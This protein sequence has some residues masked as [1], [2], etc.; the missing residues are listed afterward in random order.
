MSN[1]RKIKLFEAF[2]W[3]GSQHQALKN[4][5]IETE[6]VW[7][8]DWFISA[9]VSYWVTHLWIKPEKIDR[10]ETIE[11]LSQFSLSSD[12]KKPIKSLKSISEEHLSILEQ[13][14]KKYWELD[15]TK[16]KWEN[17]WE[18]DLFT[19]S[20]P[21]F[22]WDTKVYT[23]NWYKNIKDVEVWDM[24]LTHTWEYKKVLSVF[25]NWE[26]EVYKVNWKNTYDLYVTPNH[27]FFIREHISE[28]DENWI[29]FPIKDEIWFK[30][31]WSLPWWYENLRHY[32]WFPINK[33]E[34]EFFLENWRLYRNWLYKNREF[35]KFVWLFFSRWFVL[36]WKA[37]WVGFFIENIDLEMKEWLC[38][39]LQEH[40]FFYKIKTIENWEI[41]KWYNFFVEEK[42][43]WRFFKEFV[44]NENEKQ[45]KFIDNRILNLK[46]EY[47]SAFIEWALFI[48][49][50]SV[51]GWFLYNENIEMQMAI[52]QICFKLWLKATLKKIGWQKYCF[53]MVS[54]NAKFTD[55][56]NWYF[57]TKL[58]YEN[59]LI[60]HWKEL[61]YD[62]EVED[63]HSYTA[64]NKAVHN[65]QD[66]SKQGQEKWF[67][68]W[69]WTRSG[70]LWEVERI[71]KEMKKKP[72][73]LLM[74]N[75]KNILNFKE[76]LQEWISELENLWYKSTKPF[77]VKAS[78]VWSTQQRERVFLVSILQDEE[79]KEFE[80]EKRKQN[81]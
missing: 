72:K 31:I 6:I 10:K 2:S 18:V 68:K 49:E 40:Q 3:I 22:V 25:C 69:E 13:V 58:H 19:Y 67:K 11:F 47:L 60:Y 50:N 14:I 81:H 12:S 51:K 70:L 4:L 75:V 57:W 37:K 9:I 16:I 76:D 42:T 35:W 17:I 29:D 23:E 65:C 80:F 71:I 30:E 32:V 34:D 55:F 43:L 64:N 5:W 73:V 8:S 24:V 28:E 36:N 27:K 45:K 20:F 46:K 79:I 61:V 39:F 15:I 44:K 38:S 59:K 63:N 7:I 53:L 54:P 52:Q 74:E 48:R 21:C 78:D 62:L 26:K 77:V 66:I 33:N 1:W 56:H 41:V